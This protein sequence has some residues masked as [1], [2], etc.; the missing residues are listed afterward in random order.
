MSPNDENSISHGSGEDTFLPLLVALVLML[1]LAP[2][3]HLLPLL[4]TT[5]APLVLLA[6][7]WAVLRD[8]TFRMLL[9]AA[10]LVCLPLRWSAHFFGTQAPLLILLS[11]AT[12]GI[13]FAIMEVAVVVRVLGHQRITRQTVIGAICGYLLIAFVARL[14]GAM[15]KQD[16]H[17]VTAKRRE[18]EQR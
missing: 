13:T 4:V 12:V 16:T 10:L 6:G 9:G 5:L 2:L 8:R 14:V 3:L 11:H 18:E 15:S 7:L 1:V 17:D